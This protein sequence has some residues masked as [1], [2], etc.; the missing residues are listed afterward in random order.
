VSLDSP[1]REP[2]PRVERGRRGGRARWDKDAAA[3][4][5]P[6]GPRVLR[7]AD[8]TPTQRRLI[9]ALLELDA[10]PPAPGKE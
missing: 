8:L 5:L 9:L 1:A 2:V 4:G 3:R 10:A 6:P 7:L